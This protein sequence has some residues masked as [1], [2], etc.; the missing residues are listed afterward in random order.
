MVNPYTSEMLRTFIKR[1]MIKKL[2]DVPLFLIDEL[3]DQIVKEVEMNFVDKY[4]DYLNA[5]HGAN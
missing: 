5:M 4:T 3:V 1:T 2:P